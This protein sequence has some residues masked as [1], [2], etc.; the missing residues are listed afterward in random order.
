VPAG[1]RAE[2]AQ[3]P[4]PRQ[5]KLPPKLGLGSPLFLSNRSQGQKNRPIAAIGPADHF[6]DAVQE[7]WAGRFKDRFIICAEPPERETA[8]ARQPSEC[9]GEPK[10]Q[11]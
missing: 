7:D 5:F 4:R 1:Q 3:D 8:T 6:L 10:G 2:G 11:T 9:I